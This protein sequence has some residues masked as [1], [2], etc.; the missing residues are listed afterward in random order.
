[1]NSCTGHSKVPE[2]AVVMR[3]SWVLPGTTSRFR[4][5]GY[6]SETWDLSSLFLC[7]WFYFKLLISCVISIYGNTYPSMLSV[8]RTFL[9]C[10]CQLVQTQPSPNSYSS[11]QKKA[12]GWPHPNR[13]LLPNCVNSWTARGT[14]META[15]VKSMSKAMLTTHQDNSSAWECFLGIHSWWRMCLKPLFGR[16]YSERPKKL[17]PKWHYSPAW[18]WL[19]ASKTL[20]QDSHPVLRSWEGV[21]FLFP[22]GKKAVLVCETC[23]SWSHFCPDTAQRARRPDSSGHDVSGGTGWIAKKF[24]RLSKGTLISTASLIFAGQ[25]LLTCLKPRRAYIF[26]D[27]N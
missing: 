27:K 2:A 17:P 6:I 8:L 10:W 22:Q 20:L 3:Q 25:P 24:Q 19:A 9:W 26:I 23:D 18:T 11:G 14:L 4:S 12:K 15:W 13:L 1:M 5:I 16:A 21:F 7:F